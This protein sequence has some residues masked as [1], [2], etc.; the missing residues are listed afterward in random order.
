MR[1][2]RVFIALAAI[3]LTPSVMAQ[4]MSGGAGP[5]GDLQAQLDALT[6]QV[7]IL[8]GA[9][10][11]LDCDAGDFI[12]EALVAGYT[13]IGFTGTCTE[14]IEITRS[15][16]TLAGIGAGSEIEGN[17]T[18]TG[19]T[20]VVLS[21]FTIDG[22]GT[23]GAGYNVVV[24][25]GSHVTLDD[26]DINVGRLSANRNSGA[27][28]LGGSILGGTADNA[29]E[30]FRNSLIRIDGTTVT[31]NAAG[32]VAVQ[33]GGN[34]YLHVVTG[35]IAGAG[36]SALRIFED[37]GARLDAGSTVTG[38]VVIDHLST[39][40]GVGAPLFTGNVDISQGSA[41]MARGGV[42]TVTGSVT[43]ADLKSSQGGGVV[44]AGGTNCTSF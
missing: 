8:S 20:G 11:V 37:S 22:T 26:V 14:T 5:V 21:N 16:V 4:G 23:G 7:D 38:T 6:A 12:L 28:V 31:G 43:C 13:E 33:F 39:V 34:S 1:S 3:V 17:I 10:F 27:S 2:T 36:G 30:A 32:P 29:M 24:L 15:G 41:L 35:T 19:A 44:A 25:D 18:I 9:P 40:L 42:T